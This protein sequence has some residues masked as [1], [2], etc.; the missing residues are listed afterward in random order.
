MRSYPLEFQDPVLSAVDGLVKAAKKQPFLP[1]AD[2]TFAGDT[3]RY[4]IGAII[5]AAHARGG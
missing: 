4:N 2:C 1:G 3:R 5:D